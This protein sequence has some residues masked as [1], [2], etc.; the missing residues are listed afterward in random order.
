MVKLFQE[1]FQKDFKLFLTL[2]CKE[3]V[4][5]GRM[6]LTFLGRKTEEMLAHGE[7]GS[8]WELL[9]EAL[10]TLVQKVECVKNLNEIYDNSYIQLIIR[11]RPRN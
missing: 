7:V 2:R 10:Q 8:M 5:G 6:V 1:Q 9:A 11:T 3:L 4:G